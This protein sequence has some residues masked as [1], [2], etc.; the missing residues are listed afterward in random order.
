MAASRSLAGP[1][2][3]ERPHDGSSR[4]PRSS[5]VICDHVRPGHGASSPASTARSAAP[6]CA[7]G[8]RCRRALLSPPRAQPPR[9]RRA[10]RGR[11]RRLH[12]VAA[13][14]AACSRLRC[15][16]ASRA[17]ATGRRL[18]RA[19]AAIARPAA[20]GRRAAAVARRRRPPPRRRRRRGA[21][22]AAD[23]VAR[24]RRLVLLLVRGVLL[25]VIGPLLPPRRR[26]PRPWDDLW[27][28]GA[29]VMSR[30]V[31]S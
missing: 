27:C 5:R 3:G 19:A 8:R 25:A 10:A 9:P 22:G 16:A 31:P 6:A 24:L 15:S 7:R 29:R 30:R 4:R 11:G 18:G 14:G 13:R 17:D 28:G 21:A 12:A 20:G 23:A 2:R 26:A 1:P